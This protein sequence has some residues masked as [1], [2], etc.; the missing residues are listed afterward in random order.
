MN[1]RLL[2]SIETT[3]SF[4]RTSKPSSELNSTVKSLIIG[5]ANFDCQRFIEERQLQ[6]ARDASGNEGVLLK[7]DANACGSELKSKYIA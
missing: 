5:Q 3:F 2:T 4:S 1:S 7:F 6:E